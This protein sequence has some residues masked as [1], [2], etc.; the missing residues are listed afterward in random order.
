MVS[1]AADN[2]KAGSEARRPFAL[3]VWTIEGFL[4][5][6]GNCS[7]DGGAT[8]GLLPLFVKPGLKAIGTPNRPFT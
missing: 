1:L 7:S 4:F 5:L 8:V 3:V 6:A 2:E